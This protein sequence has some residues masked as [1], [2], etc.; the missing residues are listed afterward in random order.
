MIALLTSKCNIPT[1]R[2]YSTN[3]NPCHARSLDL[4]ERVQAVLPKNLFVKPFLSFEDMNSLHYQMVT[5]DAAHGM[6]R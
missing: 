2:S 3:S 6:C 1:L 4:G 5:S